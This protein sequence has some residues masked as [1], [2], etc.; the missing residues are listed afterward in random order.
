MVVK[1][2]ARSLSTSMACF[3]FPRYRMSAGCE[4][5]SVCSHGPKNAIRELAKAGLDLET[6]IELTWE[7]ADGNAK[8]VSLVAEVKTSNSRI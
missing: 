1:L 2:V 3:T 6:N 4:S 7:K 8:L 5:D